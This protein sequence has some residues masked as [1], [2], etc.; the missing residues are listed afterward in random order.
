VDTSGSD[1]SFDGSPIQVCRAVA[2]QVKQPPSMTSSRSQSPTLTW[3]R[4]T[5]PA[6][7][8]VRFLAAFFLRRLV[9][10]IAM[11]TAEVRAPRGT[12]DIPREW[13]PRSE[14]VLHSFGLHPCLHFTTGRLMAKR[15]AF[16]FGKPDLQ[17]SIPSISFHLF[18][19]SGLSEVFLSGPELQ[20]FSW[21]KPGTRVLH[22]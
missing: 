21:S 4:R 11:G 3:H 22:S 7:T 18:L 1:K 19:P 13:I 10:R 14:P 6:L 2:A 17:G 16:I 9:S 20:F 5:L 8:G 15:I 12:A